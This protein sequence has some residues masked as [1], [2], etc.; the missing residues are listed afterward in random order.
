MAK[1]NSKDVGLYVNQGDEETPDWVLIACSTSDGFNGTTDNVEI[2][3][4]CNDGFKENLPSSKSWEFSNSG[5]AETESEEGQE[6]YASAES[7]WRNG[8]VKQ[9]KI[10]SSDEED[11]YRM[12]KGYI[13]SYS[14]T[15]A[16]GDY[17]QFEL[18]VTGTGQY[19][20]EPPAE[21]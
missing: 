13:S 4:K 1:I 17:L 20:V 16:E 8:D 15:A 2:A 6:S 3:T 10:A 9:F 7:L 21:V 19:V 18:T 12:G 14:E 11:Y 5:Y